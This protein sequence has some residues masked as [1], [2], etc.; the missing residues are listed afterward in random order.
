MSFEVEVKYRS[1]AGHAALAARLTE[2]GARRDAAIAQT[3]VYLS[4]P[5]RDFQVT[6]EA[7]R[8]RRVGEAN[9]VTY[10]GPRRA[11]P[12]KTREEIEIPFV[13][14]DATF[15]QLTRMLDR[16]GFKEVAAVRKSRVAF[17][18]R[19]LDRAIEVVLDEVNE[20][21]DFA[22]VETLAEGEADLAAAQHAVLELARTLGLT[23]V[24]PRSYLSLVLRA[25]RTER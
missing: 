12:T 4:H 3:D 19:F 2:L 22:E 15:E 23:D 20:I 5:A 11:G 13:P 25:S 1:T 7:F 6:N 24:E 17:H 10:K 18:L 8:V 14:G 16:L 21:G 9:F